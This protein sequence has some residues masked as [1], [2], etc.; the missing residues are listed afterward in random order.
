MV[1][2]FKSAGEVDLGTAA[3][4]LRTPLQRQELEL[5]LDTEHA[6]FAEPPMAIGIADAVVRFARPGAVILVS[7]SAFRI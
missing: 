1:A 5:I 3:A 6:E 4:T 2:R 7:H